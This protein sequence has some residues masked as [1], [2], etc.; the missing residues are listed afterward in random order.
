MGNEAAHL[1]NSAVD[2]SAVRAGGN[3]S[4]TA[5]TNSDGDATATSVSD[6]ATAQSFADAVGIAN[7]AFEGEANAT[8]TATAVNTGSIKAT[9]VGDGTV[10][11]G[12]GADQAIASGDLSAVGIDV[13]D[14]LGNTGLDISGNASLAGTAG[15][16]TDIGAAITLGDALATGD[17]SG[18]G[19][20][21]DHGDIGGTATF[22]GIGLIDVSSITAD[23]GSDGLAS[24]TGSLSVLGLDVADFL[25]VGGAASL[26]SQASAKLTTS[27]T[28]VGGDAIAML[29]N[30]LP[31]GAFDIAGMTLGSLDLQS[32]G[33][34]KSVL[35]D[36]FK[37]QAQTVKG[38][39]IADSKHSLLGIGF[40]G[41]GSSVAGDVSVTS[42]LS[43]TSFSDAQSV[44]GLATASE[45]LSAIGVDVSNLAVDGSATFSS[46]VVVRATSSSDS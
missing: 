18:L 8:I 42:V 41:P 33:S 2:N 24:A 10:G 7:S 38:D 30:D 40:N 22:K 23:V 12:V 19:I 26:E 37:T 46:N 32:N 29:N 44:H 34:F 45:H 21:I 9:T 1:S 4:V 20:Q 13:D 35:V 15:L 43:H 11:G 6:N 28:N 16:Q 25:K 39:A 5:T 3:L 17:L 14:L 31:V 27:A 36:D